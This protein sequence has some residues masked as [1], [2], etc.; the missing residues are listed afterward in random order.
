MWHE[1]ALHQTEDLKHQGLRNRAREL[2]LLLVE[3][4]V[5]EV[6]SDV[7]GERAL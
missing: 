3:Q 5:Q 1:R 2:I 7:T 4:H 6:G